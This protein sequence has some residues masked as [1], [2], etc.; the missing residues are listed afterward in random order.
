MEEANGDFDKAIETIRKK[1]QLVAAKRA[2]REATEGVVIAKVSPDGTFGALTVVC[3]ETDFVAKN[4]S[5]I[6]FATSIND[7]VVAQKP[8]DIESAK[9][10]K[11]GN[12]SVTDAILEK[13]GLIGGKD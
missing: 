2:D 10:L 8:V 11:I 13:V 1:G 12:Q 9:K 5:F 4:E 7:L 3:S 6:Q